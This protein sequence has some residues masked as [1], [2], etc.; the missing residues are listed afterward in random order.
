[1]SRDPLETLPPPPR[2]PRTRLPPSPLDSER[3]LRYLLGI[4]VAVGA[5]LVAAAFVT[6]FLV[7]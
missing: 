6:I 7:D 2:P 1:M 4:V 3:F 5:L